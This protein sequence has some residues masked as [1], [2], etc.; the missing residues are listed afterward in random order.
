M[1]HVDFTAYALSMLQQYALMR[2][3]TELAPGPFYSNK[4]VQLV[5]IY[6]LV[7]FGDIPSNIA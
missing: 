6:V 3:S 7:K 5:D 4:N 1:L 2:N